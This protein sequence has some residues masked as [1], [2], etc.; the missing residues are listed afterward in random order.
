MYNKTKLVWLLA[1]LGV[2]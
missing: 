2:G 1:L